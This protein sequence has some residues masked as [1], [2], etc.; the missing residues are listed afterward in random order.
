MMD[1]GAAST[2]KEKITIIEDRY[3]LVDKIHQI[4]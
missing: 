1:E 2:K 4:R 3:S